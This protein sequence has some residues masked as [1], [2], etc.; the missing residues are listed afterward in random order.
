MPWALGCL[1]PES[2]LYHAKINS[3]SQD[4][5]E[6]VSILLAKMKIDQL[7]H[8]FIGSKCQLAVDLLLR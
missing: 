5:R 4:K 7:F 1:Y 2:Q 6:I 3:K 8:Q